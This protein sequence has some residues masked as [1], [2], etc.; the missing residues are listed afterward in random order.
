MS[1]SGA[2]VSARCI[3]SASISR[4]TSLSRSRIPRSTLSK[5]MSSALRLRISARYAESSRS[6]GVS[7]RSV[8]MRHRLAQEHPCATLDR[9]DPCR[10]R[11]HD[12][13][14]PVLDLYPSCLIACTSLLGL[15][16]YEVNP[17][18]GEAGPRDGAADHP[19][20]ASG[21]TRVRASR[22]GPAEAPDARVD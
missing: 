11:S 10:F 16:D 15:G 22:D 13:W 2:T 21:D 5:S 9:H 20:D 8:F 14:M 19:Q 3:A 17:N 18:E 12:Q 4:P 6:A 7:M 1:T